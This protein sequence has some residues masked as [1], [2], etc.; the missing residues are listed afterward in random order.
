MVPAEVQIIY[1]HTLF[2]ATVAYLSACLCNVCPTNSPGGDA[3]LSQAPGLDGSCTV[4]VT[5]HS[6]ERQHDLEYILESV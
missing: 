2:E 1:A 3:L 6:E 5:D 4:H